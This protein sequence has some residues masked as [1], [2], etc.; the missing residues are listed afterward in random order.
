MRGFLDSVAATAP[1][2]LQLHS[3]VG[4]REVPG[5]LSVATWH[6]CGGLH[7]SASLARA[8]NPPGGFCRWLVFSFFAD[9]FP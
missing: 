9:A 4:A 5:A 1:M 7:S 2:D 3:R 6:F 8:C